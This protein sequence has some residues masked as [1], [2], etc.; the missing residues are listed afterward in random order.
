MS[1]IDAENAAPISTDLAQEL[2]IL[3]PCVNSMT[4]IPDVQYIQFAELCD[5][6]AWNSTRGTYPIGY[7]IHARIED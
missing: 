2:S 1:A 6:T 3:I 4:W 5:P 7:Q